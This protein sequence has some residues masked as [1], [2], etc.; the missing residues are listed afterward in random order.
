[1]DS[2]KSL[3]SNE[4]NNIGKENQTQKTIGEKLIEDETSEIG[5]VK[6]IFIILTV[7][8]TALQKKIL[9]I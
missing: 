6:I 4:C 7:D 8:N 9:C 3:I 2:R 5:S 1:M